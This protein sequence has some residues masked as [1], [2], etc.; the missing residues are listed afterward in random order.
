MPQVRS[1]AKGKQAEPVLKSSDF[2]TYLSEQAA[3]MAPGDVE[4]AL[5]QREEASD[6]AAKDAS[7]HPRL[8][9]QVDLALQLLSDHDAGACPQV[10][11][12]TIALLTAAVLYLLNPMDV[13]PD[14]LPG[15]TSDDA[16][17]MELAF[18][19]GAP[20]I[21]RYCT[22]KEIPIDGLIGPSKPAK[23]RQT[24]R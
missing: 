19:M 15:G 6:K 24:K 20:G 7:R 5:V 23:R 18:E 1:K 8:P 16:L 10:P 4:T 14:W 11:F 3:L 2:S 21:E 13:I 17:I 9:R 22:W 12:Q